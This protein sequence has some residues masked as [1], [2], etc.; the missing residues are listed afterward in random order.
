[1]TPKPPARAAKPEPCA[2]HA[3]LPAS[4]APAS[5]APASP[6]PA[7][8]CVPPALSAKSLAPTEP[9]VRVEPT[10]LSVLHWG[11]LLDGELFA[12]SRYVQRAVLMKRTFR[13]D[14]LRCPRYERK[15]RVLSTNTDP[16]AV[17]RILDHLNLPS[18][19]TAAAPAR[20]P[21]WESMAFGFDAA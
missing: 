9:A 6:A 21:T 12:T 2:G 18:H 15:M 13:F 7:S 1:M 10:T 5:P 19:P 4:P 20:D 3:P 17:R 8:P 11:R 16:K 14:A